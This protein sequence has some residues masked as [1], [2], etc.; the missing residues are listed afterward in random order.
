[1]YSFLVGDSSEYKK[2]K[3][4]NKN[5]AKTII[6][7]EYNDVLLSNKCFRYLMKRIWSKDHKTGTHENQHV[8]MIK[9]ISRTMNMMDWLLVIGSYYTKNSYLNN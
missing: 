4:V 1:M 7:N 8:L 2:A 9:Y 5:V 3:G 6:H